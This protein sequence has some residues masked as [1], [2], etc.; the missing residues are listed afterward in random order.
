MELA[1]LSQSRPIVL[2]INSAEIGGAEKQLVRLAGEMT[3]QGVRV[4]VIFMISGGPLTAELDK[5]SIPWRNFNIQIRE[6]RFRSLL[7]AFRLGVFLR[8][9]N[10]IVINAWLVEC[11]AVTFIVS[12][13]FS[14]GS[15]RIASFR[16]NPQRK[17]RSLQPLFSRVFRMTDGIIC[18][19][20]HL[21]DGVVSTFNV[22]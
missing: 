17:R 7:N 11:A 4:E 12:S 3:S 10:P 1:R 5:Y 19:A 14:P 13:V 20:Q 18:N 8:K 15:L 16:G 22:Y 9:L 21:A 6:H 2:V